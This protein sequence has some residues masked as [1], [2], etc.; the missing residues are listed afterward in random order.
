MSLSAQWW[1]VR[2]GPQLYQCRVKSLTDQATATGE[3]I[4]L[5]SCVALMVWH[6]WDRLVVDM[7]LASSPAGAVHRRRVLGELTVSHEP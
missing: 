7:P 2:R 4:G 5:P 6:L 3:M 1:L